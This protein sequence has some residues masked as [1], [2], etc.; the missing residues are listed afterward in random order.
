M[1]VTQKNIKNINKNIK[2]LKKEITKINRHQK[3]LIVN[4]LY[5]SIKW[6]NNRRLVLIIDKI[7]I[8]LI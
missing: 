2:K 1:S 4:F 7:S 5:N 6:E 8:N 3:E